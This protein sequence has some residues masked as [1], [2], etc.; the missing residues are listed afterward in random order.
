[1]CKVRS[2]ETGRCSS[3]CVAVAIIESGWSTIE[4]QQEQATLSPQSSLAQRRP[5]PLPTPVSVTNGRTRSALATWGFARRHLEV[6]Q[7]GEKE[8][9]AEPWSQWTRPGAS[10]EC[11]RHDRRPRSRAERL[12][13]R[14][15]D[16]LGRADVVVPLNF[17]D[18][19]GCSRG[20][21]AGVGDMA[22]VTVGPL[23]F[24]DRHGRGSFLPP[25]RSHVPP[26]KIFFR[27]QESEKDTSTLCGSE[28]AETV[29]R[30]C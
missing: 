2:C 10:L 6:S 3:R 28:N 22:P 16:R 14:A 4:L 13:D 27:R 17:S 15:A 20:H 7:G 30:C 11:Q 21:R 5:P 12:L 29:P 8:F 18:Q 23:N 1:M 9:A 24:A 26:P 25:L 19:H